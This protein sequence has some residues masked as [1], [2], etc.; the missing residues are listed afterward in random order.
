MVL[1][2]FTWILHL[3][4]KIKGDPESDDANIV[5]N[6]EISRQNDY[7]WPRIYKKWQMLTSWFHNK[8]DRNRD[9]QLILRYIA[10][11]ARCP[12]ISIIDAKSGKECKAKGLKAFVQYRILIVRKTSK[13]DRFE[14][15]LYLFGSKTWRRT[16]NPY[17]HCRP[18]AYYDVEGVNGNPS[19]VNGAMHWY[20]GEIMIFD[21]I[22]EDF[23]CMP[24]PGGDTDK[25]SYNQ[26]LLVNEDRLCCFCTSCQ[27]S[28]INVWILEDYANWTWNRKY[29]ININWNTIKYPFLAGL[30]VYGAASSVRVISIHKD[31]VILFWMYRGMFSYDLCLNTVKKIQLRKCAEFDEYLSDYDRSCGFLAYTKT[32][33]DF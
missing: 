15:H 33:T 27:V 6:E 5:V 29:T 31:E 25:A 24:F 30:S 9:S 32:T 11:T 7:Q 8:E 28:E 16:A 13:V 4:K 26:K 10:F 3:F 12:K 23:C 2:C 21:M 19:I 22:S 1:E 18:L 14:Y 17:F 20:V